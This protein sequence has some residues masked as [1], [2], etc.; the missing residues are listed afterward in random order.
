MKLVQLARS[1][2]PR[3]L[4]PV[5]LLALSGV[6]APFAAAAQTGLASPV[7]AITT[8]SPSP[9]T[10]KNLHGAKVVVSLTGVIFVAGFP[11]SDD[12]E[13]VTE[14]PGLAIDVVDRFY[15][16]DTDRHARDRVEV[17]L[18]YDG[19]DFDTDETL[20]VT[21]K[22]AAHG[23]GA[24]LTTGTVPVTA[25]QEAADA[26][27]GG[28]TLSPGTLAPAFAGGTTTYT[29]TVAATVTALTVTATASDTNASVTVN[30][31]A[32]TSGRASHAV[33]LAAAA[34]RRWWPSW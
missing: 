3:L 11:D 15:D 29:A 7:A 17:R 16:R 20:A 14:I 18:Q 21:V 13:L 32:V 19:T 4:L 30:G 31:R 25:T 9:L 8:T 2:R 27:L 34:V 23:G 33:A 28:L 1:T 24:D 22:A 6:S 26:T 10:E 5:C 12:F